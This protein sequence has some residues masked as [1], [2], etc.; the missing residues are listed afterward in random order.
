MINYLSTNTNRTEPCEL[1]IVMNWLELTRLEEAV[2]CSW[3]GFG[4]A[5]ANGLKKKRQWYNLRDALLYTSSKQ[6]VLFCRQELKV[7]RAVKWEAG[8]T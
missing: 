2:A 5:T 8:T 7:C 4:S 3:R 6:V 1:G